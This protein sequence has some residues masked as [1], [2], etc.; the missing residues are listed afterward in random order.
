MVLVLAVETLFD[1]NVIV[2]DSCIVDMTIPHL[3]TSCCRAWVGRLMMAVVLV[4]PFCM[5]STHAFS[6]SS[7]QIL[8]I[9]IVGIVFL[10][11]LQMLLISSVLPAPFPSLIPMLRGTPGISTG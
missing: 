4:L 6:L 8:L 5:H 1:L 3:T 7:Q 2:V 10:V 9:V 11:A